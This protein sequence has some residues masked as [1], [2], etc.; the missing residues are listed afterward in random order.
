M[1]FRQQG[2]DR[3]QRADGEYRNFRALLLAG[4]IANNQAAYPEDVPG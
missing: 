3:N 1:N 2:Q 4:H